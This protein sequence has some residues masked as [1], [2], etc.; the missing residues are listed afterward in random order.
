[1]FDLK[2]ARY[3]LLIVVVAMLFGAVYAQEETTTVEPPTPIPPTALPQIPSVDYFEP[4]M[5]VSDR[6]NVLT[7]RGRHF[8]PESVVRIAGYGVVSTTYVNAD[9]LS[10]T[11]PENIVPGIYNITVINPIG[12]SALS[13]GRLTVLFPVQPTQQPPEPP[14]PPTAVPGAPNLV[15]RDY[16]V[17]PNTVTPNNP[18]TITFNILNQGNYAALGVS[19]AV[20]T[21]SKFMPAGGQASVIVSDINPNGTA[22]VTMPLIAPPDATGIMSVPVDINYRDQNGNNHTAKAMFSVA[23]ADV[24]NLP[25]L[26]LSRYMVMPSFVSAG[27][28]VVVQLL[29][30]NHGTGTAHQILMRLGEGVLLAGG[31]G[32]SV[33]FG[34]LGAGESRAMSIPLIVSGGAEAGPQRQNFTLTYLDNGESKQVDSSITVQVE[35]SAKAEPFLLLQSYS[36]EQDDEVMMLLKPSERFTLKATIQN[37]GQAIAENVYISFNASSEGG[38]SGG[39]SAFTPVG[40]GGTTFFSKMDGNG[41][42]IAIEQ[43][44]VVNSGVTSGVHA[45]QMTVSYREPGGETKQTTFTPSV[46]VVRPARLNLALVGSLPPEIPQG[47]PLSFSLTVTNNDERTIDVRRIEIFAEGAE[48]LDGG[49]ASPGNIVKDRNSRLDVLLLPSEE[50]EFEFSVRVDYVDD[51]G[52]VQSLT[53]TYSV[54]VSAPLEPWFPD[55][56]GEGFEPPMPDPDPE[57]EPETGLGDDW[58]GRFI[59]GFLGLGS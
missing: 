56:E 23:V 20:D 48:I 51:L 6:S 37:V 41:T 32:D 54:M 19:V 17:D 3:G 22:R 11:L 33:S 28:A 30:T 8:V 44:F 59:M 31:Q 42:Q 57:P 16:S 39:A 9:T 36:F 52:G 40:I 24:V 10:A 27:D 50:G 26:S 58:L 2:K 53:N 13:A 25:Q 47:E 35:A 34:D 15:A 29:L 4:T 49:S 18:F 21:S 43:D 1:M 46:L 55:D 38:G 5:I 7:I 12:E 45:I 14:A